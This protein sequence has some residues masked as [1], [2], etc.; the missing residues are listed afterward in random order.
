MCWFQGFNDPDF[1]KINKKC[2]NKWEAL[3]PKWNINKLTYQNIYKYTPEFFDIIKNSPKRSFPAQSDLLRI[4]LLY[5]FGGVWADVNVYPTMPLKNIV[6]N[7]LNETG[8][9]AYRFMP[10]LDK[11]SG[12][13]EIASWFLCVDKPKRYI[14]KKWKEEFIK[15]FKSSE[16][17]IYFSFHQTLCDLYDSDHEVRKII[18]NMK[19]LNQS[20][21]HSKQK[22][23]YKSIPSYVYKKNKK[24]FFQLH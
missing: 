13:R 23:K 12:S 9:F 6:K 5:K 3:N 8:F 15:R 7:T 10:R 21:P 1:P 16:N 14:I 20:A 18:N 19:Q 24:T 11:D 22:S 17:F 2:V 4:L